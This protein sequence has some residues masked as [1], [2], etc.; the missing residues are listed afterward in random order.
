MN[1]LIP[2]SSPL[3]PLVS[4]TSRRSCGTTVRSAGPH[5]TDEE[6]ESREMKGHPDITL[7]VR[8]T[9]GSPAGVPPG[10]PVSTLSVSLP[11]ESAGEE[12]GSTLWASTALEW[13]ACCSACR[14][15][16][17]QLGPPFS[18]R[19]Q[20]FCQDPLV[21]FHAKNPMS[22]K[23]D[24]TKLCVRLLTSAVEWFPLGKSS[25]VGRLLVAV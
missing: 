4:V 23:K 7:L 8:G 20:S 16:S 3:A 19:T 21:N 9:A 12:S 25:T 14:P 15:H 17:R 18:P 11:S 2:T 1:F 5:F 6:S 10:C 13:H 22:V 24:K